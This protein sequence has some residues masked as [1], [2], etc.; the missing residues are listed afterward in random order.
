MPHS[1]IGITGGHGVLGRRLQTM[2]RS[3]GR[4]FTLFSGDVRNLADLQAGLAGCGVVVHLAAI[5]EPA[6][7]FAEPSNCMEV[8]A[9]GTARVMEACR[10]LGIQRAIYTSTAQVYGAPARLPADE[11]SPTAPRSVY[12]ASKLAGE[13]AM[14]GY[15]A[16]FGTAA[17]AARLANV[18]GPGMG[19]QSV[20]GRAVS[21][22]RSGQPVQ[23]RSYREVRDFIF[24]DDAVEALIRLSGADACGIGFHTVNVSSARGAS[25]MDVVEVLAAVAEESGLPRPEI[26]PPTGEPDREVPALV[27]D[28]RRLQSLTGWQPGTPLREGL[29]HSL[30]GPVP[31]SPSR[32]TKL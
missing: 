25:V 23:L 29:A 14:R 9:L 22:L 21:Q 7:C 10:L 28:N 24:L 32:C 1:H 4:A 15:S 20:I 2:L 16:S 17:V 12:A 27:L 3:A 30:A 26:L 11:D 19:P 18:Y 13:A 8:N 6:A 5:S 31:N